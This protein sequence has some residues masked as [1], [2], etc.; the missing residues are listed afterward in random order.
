MGSGGNN[1]AIGHGVGVEA[2]GDHASH[3][4]HIHHQ[5]STH[6]VGDSAQAGK[7]NTRG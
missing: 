6:A 4:G 5:I 2:N 3:V 7:S 1:I